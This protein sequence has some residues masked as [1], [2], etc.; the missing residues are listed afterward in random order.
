MLKVYY[1][2]YYLFY[3]KVLVQRDPNLV[4]TL[5]ISH[6]ESLLINGII[7]VVFVTKYCYN[8]D[9]WVMISIALLVIIS[10]FIFYHKSNL[11]KKIVQ[12]KPMFFSNHKLTIYIVLLSSLIVISWM[13]WGAFY[14]RSVL[15]N[16]S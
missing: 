15:S 5:A 16:C 6:V 4:T 10:N 8:V 2:Y 3:T 11:A 9:M 1:Y 14:S 13:F 12:E 7:D